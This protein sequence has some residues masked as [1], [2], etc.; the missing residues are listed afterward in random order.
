ME[1]A[2]VSRRVRLE[3]LKRRKELASK[4]TNGVHRDKGE[5]P[6]ALIHFDDQDEQTQL[7]G[8]DLA[9]LEARIRSWSTAKLV[10]S[11]RVLDRKQ[12]IDYPKLRDTIEKDIAGIQEGVIAEHEEKR[13]E[14][15][16]LHNIA[17]KRPNWD[18]KRDM[19]KRLAKL[20][21]RDREAR[22]I[23]IRQRVAAASKGA[24]ATDGAQAAAAAGA[25]GIGLLPE[26]GAGTDSEGEEEGG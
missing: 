3:E 22:L 21:R 5:E 8:T 10:R 17:P 26:A 4:A 2:S 23:L 20:E 7:E 13:K 6:V 25:L 11:F 24:D 12:R 16:D 14:D 15:L 9:A 19:Q 1:A 18:L